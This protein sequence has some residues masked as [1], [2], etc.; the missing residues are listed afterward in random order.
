MV[1]DRAF[2]FHIMLCL[3]DSF[4]GTKIKVICQGQN[5]AY[6]CKQPAYAPVPTTFSKAFS[7]NVVQNLDCEVKE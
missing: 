4:L 7:L 1:R 5:I 6:A 2:I 3:V